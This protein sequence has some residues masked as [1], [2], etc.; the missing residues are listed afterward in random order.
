MKKSV[1]DLIRLAKE[2]FGDDTIKIDTII[3]A[4]ESYD[5]MAMVQFMIDIEAGFG[6]ELKDDAIDKAMTIQEVWTIIE[7]KEV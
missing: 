2:T 1:D 6:I 5:S 7:Q 3:G 4:I